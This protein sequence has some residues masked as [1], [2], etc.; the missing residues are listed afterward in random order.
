MSDQ[1]PQIQVLGFLTQEEEKFF[2]EI[3]DKVSLVFHEIGTLEYEKKLL[4]NKVSKFELSAKTKKE[5]IRSRVGLGKKDQFTIRGGKILS[6]VQPDAK[7]ED[8]E[9]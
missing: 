2:S 5:E 9:E 8:H 7:E 1:K 3:N 4:L 6:L